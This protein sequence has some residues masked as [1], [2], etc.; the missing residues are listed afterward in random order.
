MGNISRLPV[1]AKVIVSAAVTATEAIEDH[2][3]KNLRKTTSSASEKLQKLL[4]VSIIGGER[5]E[6][7]GGDGGSYSGGVVRNPLTCYSFFME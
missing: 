5:R 6:E 4:A 7:R 3:V 2:R 1:C